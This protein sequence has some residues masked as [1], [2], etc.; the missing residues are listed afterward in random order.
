MFVLFQSNM[1]RNST[2]EPF[3]H[4]VSTSSGMITLSTLSTRQNSI[5]LTSLRTLDKK[6]VKFNQ[7]VELMEP[8]GEGGFGCVY[9][10]RYRGPLPKGYNSEFVAIK[11]LPS[12]LVVPVKHTLPHSVRSKRKKRSTDTAQ[13]VWPELFR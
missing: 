4:Q 2:Y 7:L 3:E 13:V 10:A 8:L 9:K 11:V 5:S 12:E 1:K 6:M